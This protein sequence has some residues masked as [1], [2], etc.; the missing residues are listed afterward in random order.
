MQIH[1]DSLTIDK[2]VRFALRSSSR[3]FGNDTS[4]RNIHSLCI[5]R[6]SNLRA[7]CYK[8][9]DDKSMTGEE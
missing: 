9:E 7:G 5:V 3:T 2:I 4:Q 8:T 1:A 6:G